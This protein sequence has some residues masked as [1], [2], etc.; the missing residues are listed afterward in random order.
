MMSFLW[1]M[2]IFERHASFFGAKHFSRSQGEGI[3]SW[4]SGSLNLNRY[5][6]EPQTCYKVGLLVTNGLITPVTHLFSAI[7]KGY[8][9]ICI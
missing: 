4:V 7:D 3:G 1:N 5:E 6:Y 2:V 8:N 9:S